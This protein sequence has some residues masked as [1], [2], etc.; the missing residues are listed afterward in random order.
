MRSRFDSTRP[1]M[2]GR[3]LLSTTTT[4][5]SPRMVLRICLLYTYCT[6]AQP[7]LSRLGLVNYASPFQMTL[8]QDL[9]DPP[10]RSLVPLVS[11]HHKSL[12]ATLGIG[13]TPPVPLLCYDYII[14]MTNFIFYASAFDAC[15]LLYALSYPYLIFI[16]ECITQ[17]NYSSLPFLN[18]R[19]C[20]ILAM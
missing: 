3:V 16:K 20:E 17:R 18:C 4:H 12:C 5:R 8:Q 13:K 15:M 9:I 6:C 14:I 19:S 1:D 7:L 2:N 10:C 11:S